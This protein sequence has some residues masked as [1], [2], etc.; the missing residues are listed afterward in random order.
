[1]NP[2]ISN[3]ELIRPSTPEGFPPPT[4]QLYS[5]SILSFGV[6]CSSNINRS[7]EAHVV[8]S[9]AGLI[10]ESYGTGTQV[11]LPGRSALEPR[12]FKFG[13]PYEAM[14]KNMAG[15]DDDTA[16]FTRNGVL[17][18]CRRGAAVKLAPQRWQDTSNEDVTK[19]DV[20]IAFE[21]RIFDAV[22][23]DLQTR[24][25]TEEFQP[26]HVICLDTKDNPQQAKIQGRI[27]LEL[28]WLLEKTAEKINRSGSHSGFESESHRDGLVIE[29]PEILDAFQ[30]ER[31]KH[32]PI[33][34]LHQL[35]YL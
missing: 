14:Y 18:L 34:V 28:C 6:V 27:A 2:A 4:S 8:L 9:N 32:T 25:P 23:E 20:V 13:T 30:E 12:V 17:A 22:V 33:K 21:E 29:V 7:M 11:R 1:M 31:M 15:T 35:C 10:V 26:I 16:F 3:R 5:P 19:H 24:E